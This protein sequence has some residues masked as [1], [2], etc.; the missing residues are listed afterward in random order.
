[1]DKNNSLLTRVEF[2]ANGKSYN[3]V[4]FFYGE[5]LTATSYTES[6]TKLMEW[7]K[8][9]DP[10]MIKVVKGKFDYD[11]EAD[12]LIVLPDK[13]PY[14]KH[15][16]SHN[17][18]RRS[19]HRF[20][21]LY[22]G[23]EKI[24]LY[25]GLKDDF[26]SP[27]P[28]LLTEKGFI[29][30]IC[31]DIE[32]NQEEYV[33][34]VN[35]KVVSNMDQV[36]FNVYRSNLY[37]GLVK[38]YTRDYSFPTV[39]KDADKG[40]SIQ[41]K[42]YYTG[43]FNGDGKMEVLAVS[44]HQ[45]FGDKGKPSQCYIF[46]L[47]NNK[48]LFQNFVFPYNVDFVGTK[49]PNPEIAD[50]K[51]DKLFVMDYDGDGKTDICHINENGIDIYTFDTSGTNITGTRKI[52]SY[53]GLRKSDLAY[54]RILMGEFNGDNLTDILV[55]PSYKG[56]DYTWTVYNSKGNGMF[57]KST[58]RG[59]SNENNA[60]TGFVIQDINDDG[61]T[62]LIKYVPLGF[63]TFLA[64]NN[65]VGNSICY[66]KFSETKSILVSTDINSRNSFT[67]LLCL[68]EGTATKYSF[69]S[70]YGKE[71][72]LT[73]MVNSHGVIE[74]N[75]YSKANEEGV[76]GGVYSKGHN[77]TYPYVNI[78]EPLTL[79]ASS[80]KYV[81]GKC[82][83]GYSY[84]Y[85]N[86][87]IHRQGLGFCGFEEVTSYDKRGR[88]I[89]SK[90]D[91]YRHGIMKSVSTQTSYGE[92]EY[93]I[94]NQANHILKI[95]L[96]QKLEKDLLKDISVSTSYSYDS[97]GYPTVENISYPDGTSIKKTYA[98]SHL[99]QVGDGYN[100]GFPV[101]CS[102]TTQREGE[103]Y[104]ERL[105]IPTHS[106]RQPNIRILYKNG[107][108]VK[109][110]TF[111]YNSKGLAIN[112]SVKNF[113]AA[114]SQITKYEYDVFG[115][116]TKITD[117]MGLAT[118]FDYDDSGRI[119]TESDFRG[120]ITTYSYDEFG[121]V[122]CVTHP[123]MTQQKTSLEWMTDASGGLY[124]KTQEM[125]GKPKSTNAFDVL[126]REV[127]SSNMLLNGKELTVIKRYDDYGRLWRTS[128]PYDKSVPPI[129]NTY[130]YDEY[131]RVTSYTDASGEV[132]KYGYNGN[133]VTT[134]SKGLVK[135]M[136]YNSMGNLVSVTDPAGTIT[137]QLA[138]D[139]KPMSI[140]APGNITTSF[141]YDK[142]RRRIS[143][144]D[145]S[146]GTA[147]YEYDAAGNLSKETDANGK[148][149]QYEYDQYNRLVKSI[150]PEFTSSYKYNN[151]NDLVEVSSTNGCGKSLSYDT[152]GRVI[153][154]KQTAPDGKWLRK[155]YTYADGNVNSIEYTSQ[156]GRL[157]KEGYVYAN[158]SLKSVKLNDV[159]NV[160][161]IS[162]MNSNGMASTIFTGRITRKYDYTPAGILAGISAT[163]ISKTFQDISYTFDTNTSNLLSRKD[164]IRN[165]SENF[166]YDE[167]NRLTTFGE[168]S[169]GYDNMGNITRLSDIGSIEYDVP[170]KPYAVSGLT[171]SSANIPERIQDVKYTSFSRPQSMFEN[172]HIADFTYST[173]YERI[174]MSVSW[175]VLHHVITRYYLGGCYELDVTD[176]E[177]KERLYL[178]GD[179]Y[180][181]PAVLIKVNGVE[182]VY[183]ILRDN[184]GS[185]THVIDYDDN[186]VQEL[187]YDAWG[188]LRNPDSHQV[189]APGNEPVLFLGR[190]YTGHEH[191]TQFGLINMNARLYDAA[192]G[193]F[194]SP[195][196]YVQ[197]PDFSQ[198]FNRYSYCL[199][200]PLCYVDKDGKSFFLIFAIVTG[201]YFGGSATNGTF[202]P[203]KWN[204]GNWKTYAGMAIGGVAGYAGA[205]IGTSVA[206]TAGTS[207]ISAGMA[208]GMIGG[209]VSGSINGVGM[210]A[211]KGGGFK[212]I[213]NSMLY[214]GVISG[215]GGALSGGIGNA[216]GDFSGVVGSSFKNC[217]YEIGHS[218]LK[219]FATGLAGGAFMGAMAGNFDYLWKGAAWGAAFSAG[220]AG[221]RIGLMGTTIIPPGIEGRF[222][223]DDNAMGIR[224]TYP[225]YRRGGLLANFVSGI[226]LG[227][228][229]MAKARLLYSDDRDKQALYFETLAHERAHIYQQRIL[230]RL[231]F[232]LRTLYE[233]IINPGYRNNKPY[234]DPN[235]LEYW[236][237]QYM[238]LTP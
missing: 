223:A 35:N 91:P 65:N 29:D 39:Y 217:I 30:I 83:E 120:G 108:A 90:Y 153:Q 124:K 63:Y 9:D 146:F 116:P 226:T 219:G 112:S 74:K 231:G 34:K 2:S 183:N 66:N 143:M 221:L 151:T 117:P 111:S 181:A 54:R 194:L 136:N 89:V 115:R 193:R 189:Y 150:C 163:G 175:K 174:K 12:G 20:D 61:T 169:V 21:N 237:D 173:D 137:Y 128:M 113:S 157:A 125:T 235:C 224:N 102:S 49:Q 67:Q 59:P 161:D 98:Y 110:E 145:P 187:S 5:G 220:M 190:G 75:T 129:W 162:E 154:L 60:N 186:L 1:M 58:F 114:N 105:Y 132:T 178:G 64:N 172:G 80:D 18:F 204:Y 147:T 27:M 202:N 166:E 109:E 93:S 232:Y 180:T 85:R 14:W 103:S 44:I 56:E 158:G 101:D 215:F 119:K 4:S 17:L 208:G 167:M 33:I 121:R 233:Y 206:A 6:I 10:N 32:G 19:Q 88:R 195:D 159:I 207:S 230:G 123:D 185:I 192:L 227:R 69:T 55:S 118:E 77:A 92:Y 205:A 144:A 200:N 238:K 225:V 79:V 70:D 52:A 210:A 7:Y 160:Y 126:N 198:N 36:T 104:T 76:N 211:I 78:N 95:L 13:N 127:L 236:A 28:N 87:V 106:K 142:Y 140:T 177:K 139:G 179:Y 149:R 38:L 86:A 94:T 133:S 165:I 99:P 57:D 107:N 228:N 135:T 176:T 171:L 152:F 62:D 156:S 50:N 25:A 100:L 199:N 222:D 73:G 130:S 141:E 197:M 23:D 11:S 47:V 148:T 81:E 216:L 213:M 37:Y 170:N 131:D 15:Y 53:S 82:K 48:I 45:P 191:L 209:M 24:F 234:K 97:Y 218:A 182:K 46:D 196:P 184:L 22:K 212:D 71:A 72:L 168:K 84:R 40:K 41:P 31:G 8:S 214:G 229:M 3:P 201:I 134:E 96:T 155:D 43:D 122:T 138:P 164:N 42:Y 188:R 26:A 68:K 51:S 16:R 203:T